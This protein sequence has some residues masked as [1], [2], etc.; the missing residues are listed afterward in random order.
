MSYIKRF[1]W[2]NLY[3]SQSVF[4]FSL[5][6]HYHTSCSYRVYKSC[7]YRLFAGAVVQRCSVIEVFLEI[8]QNSQENSCAR[9]SFLNF[10]KRRL[11]HRCF[12]VNFANFL[13]PHSFLQNTSGGCFCIQPS[14]VQEI[15]FKNKLQRAKP[16]CKRR[17]NFGFYKTLLAE[18]RLEDK[19]NYKILFKYDF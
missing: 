15:W 6:L 16:W 17:K 2:Y 11:S 9:V 12:P 7:S 3:D 14:R 18:L 8:S 13:R 19:Y 4:R 5:L 1:A 10:I